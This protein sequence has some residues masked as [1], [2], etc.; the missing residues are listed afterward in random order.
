GYQLLRKVELFLRLMDLPDRHTLPWQEPGNDDQSEPGE[1][2]VFGTSSAINLDV[3]NPLDVQQAQLAALMKYDL[4]AS[5][6]E[7]IESCQRDN[8]RLT[9]EWV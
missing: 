4:F 3:R 5:L 7:N 1:T 6:I 8:R 2:T 9:Q